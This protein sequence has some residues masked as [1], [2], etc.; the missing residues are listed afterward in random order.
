MTEFCFLRLVC[1]YI[2]GI[3]FIYLL[4]V[5]LNSEMLANLE[6]NSFSSA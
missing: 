3:R 6:L 1:I 2:K 4:G 5:I